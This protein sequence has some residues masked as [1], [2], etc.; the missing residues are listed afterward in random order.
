MQSILCGFSSIFFFNNG[1]HR[2]VDGNSAHIAAIYF[3]TLD[4]AEQ[5]V[6]TT[7]MI[8]SSPPP[9]PGNDVTANDVTLKDDTIVPEKVKEPDEATTSDANPSAS[10]N[11]PAPTKTRLPAQAPIEMTAMNP[12]QTVPNTPLPYATAPNTPLPTQNHVQAMPFPGQ[13]VQPGVNVAGMPGAPGMGCAGPIPPMQ[14]GMAYAA[15]PAIMPGYPAGVPMQQMFSPPSAMP[16][17]P[18]GMAGAMGTN[19]NQNG[20]INLVVNT[21]ANSNSNSDQKGGAGAAPKPAP[22]PCPK[23]RLGYI[24]RGQARFR[25]TCIKALA[26]ATIC[27]T[28]LM[29]LKLLE[30]NYVDKC[31]YCGEEYGFR[32]ELFEKPKPPKM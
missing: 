21:N 12:P 29:P 8:S 26:Y 31:S 1:E 25:E 14:P 17:N 10:T 15:G 20:G 4:E 22:R 32:G 9:Y 6:G 28:C 30:T 13:P 19:P 11:P 3:S 7:L 24:T 5:Y 27:C 2:A 23:C 16:M 18:L